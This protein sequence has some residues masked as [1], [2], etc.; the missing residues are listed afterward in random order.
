[1]QQI[2]RTDAHKE[3]GAQ[4]KATPILAAI[5]QHIMQT[6]IPPVRPLLY[7]RL[8]NCETSYWNGFVAYILMRAKEA[9]RGEK[10][11][12]DPDAGRV[13][14]RFR[15]PSSGSD[16]RIRFDENGLD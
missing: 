1:M 8:L 7:L 2:I 16:K 11:P 12:L 6:A 13:R 9:T 3:T 14:K 4:I 10:S 15:G 5:T